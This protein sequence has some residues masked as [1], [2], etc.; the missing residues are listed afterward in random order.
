M[1]VLAAVLLARVGITAD[2]D[3]AME[4]TLNYGIT[5]GAN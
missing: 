2:A 1:A 5:P 4:V 3:A